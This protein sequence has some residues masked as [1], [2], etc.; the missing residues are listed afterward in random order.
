MM[1]NTSIIYHSESMLEMQIITMIIMHEAE[2]Y[3]IGETNF[4]LMLI[5][6]VAHL[7]SYITGIFR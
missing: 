5:L 7:F 2:D 3:L 6:F 1:Q 4:N